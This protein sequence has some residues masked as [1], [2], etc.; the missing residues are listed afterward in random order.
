MGKG[1]RRRILRVIKKNC[2]EMTT[3]MV[4]PHHGFADGIGEG[5][6]QLESHQQWP[7]QAWPARGGDTVEIHRLDVGLAQG[8]AHDLDHRCEVLA[9]RNFRHDAAVF[10]VNQYLRGDDVRTNGPTVCHDR[11]RGFVTRSLDS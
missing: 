9:R 2:R 7:D 8:L 3:Q 6:A 4:D 10:C 5:F 1:R 11:G